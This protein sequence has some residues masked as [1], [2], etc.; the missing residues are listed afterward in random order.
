[1]PNVIQV[2]KPSR[3]AY[4]PNRP[5]EKNLLIHAQ[6]LH[7]QEAEKNMPENLRTGID[8]AAIATEGQAAD[9][10]RKVTRAI[11]LSGG[12]DPGKVRTAG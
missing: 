8:A 10:I 1:M 7:F 6:V 9:Y 4:N 5:R 12:R 2:P 11:H 3:A